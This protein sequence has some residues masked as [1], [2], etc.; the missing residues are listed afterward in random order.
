[1]W[2]LISLLSL[3]GLASAQVP[4]TD[5][6]AP[7]I[8][9]DP[10]VVTPGPI[11]DLGPASF[12]FPEVGQLFLIPDPNA[13]AVYLG[14]A[15]VR[16][17]V[18]GDW[19]P[20]TFRWAGPGTPPTNITVQTALESAGDDYQFGMSLD[21][22]TGVIDS[23]PLHPVG[24]GSAV[25]T[26]RTGTGQ[27]FGRVAPIVGVAT[28]KIFPQ[29]GRIASRDVLFWTD[30]STTNIHI[31]EIDID[32]SSPSYGVVSSRHVAVRSSTIPGA[33]LVHS[34]CP[35]YDSTGETT[36]LLHSTVTTT[37]NSDPFFSSAPDQSLFVSGFV[38]SQRIVD[39]GFDWVSNPAN[40]RGTSFWADSPALNPFGDP[41][42]I[43]YFGLNSVI[44]SAA[45]GGTAVAVAQV[46]LARATGS[47]NI[48][49]LNIGPRLATPVPQA[50]LQAALGSL[51]FTFH[52]GLSVSA[53][54]PVTI[55]PVSE[56]RLSLP[57]PPL[58]LGTIIRWEA[59]LWCQ[60]S[61]DIL[62]SNTAIIEAR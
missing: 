41:L 1:M 47:T 23:G 19:D 27:Q 43:D 46:P 10:A 34:A 14:T 35:V 52:G 4:T 17:P 5:P 20:V 8:L 42:R 39:D 54:I 44:V 26:T 61:G 2:Y 29:L 48:G 50:A 11:P 53:F 6:T 22:L 12:G 30:S 56:L 3:A 9:V 60:P 21:G 18:G 13:P 51:G 36:A 57:V 37:S 55:G 24:H 58:P 49:I 31:G 59:I 33:V 40:L 16:D 7:G 45:T 25:I 28:G 15:S 38:T 32:P 62:L